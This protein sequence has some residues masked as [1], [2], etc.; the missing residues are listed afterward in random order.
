M[1]ATEDWAIE[2]CSTAEAMLAMQMVAGLVAAVLAAAWQD[3]HRGGD[4]G[5]PRSAYHRGR[6]YRY[7]ARLRCLFTPKTCRLLPCSLGGDRQLR[8]W[9]WIFQ[10]LSK[11][12]IYAV[13][14]CCLPQLAE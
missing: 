9:G 6:S 1:P 11:G 8:L 7:R 12:P 3:T 4:Y 2:A 10:H 13:D 5:Q 14:L